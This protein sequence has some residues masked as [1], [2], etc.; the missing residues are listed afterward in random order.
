MKTLILTTALCIEVL[1]TLAWTITP[2]LAANCIYNGK[3]YSPGTRIGPLVCQANGTWK[4][5]SK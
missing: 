3:S 2:A 4:D 1:L 5:T